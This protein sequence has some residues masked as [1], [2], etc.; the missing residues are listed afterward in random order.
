MK[1]PW[2]PKPWIWIAEGDV[3]SPPSAAASLEPNVIAAIEHATI[4]SRPRR[5]I[6]PLWEKGRR[7]ST[8]KQELSTVMTMIRFRSS[9]A[10]LG[11]RPRVSLAG[12]GPR[13]RVSLA[14]LGP[15]P[16][17]SLAGLGPR[18][19]TSQHR[20][21]RS[22]TYTDLGREARER[23]LAPP[24]REPPSRT[25]NRVSVG[26]ACGDRACESTSE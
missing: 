12:L 6:D 24:I 8:G 4:P 19:Q 7:L 13:P 9:L 25:V 3:G 17:V 20:S 23:R 15:R 1:A 2:L 10:G 5:V 22:R 18:P 21:L 11:P 14:G 16:R 26:A